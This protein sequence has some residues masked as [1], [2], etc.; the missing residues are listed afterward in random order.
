M[1]GTE[2][3]PI[4]TPT[5]AFAAAS[6]IADYQRWLQRSRGLR[7]DSYEELWRWSVTDLTAFWQSIWDYFE[8]QADAPASAV[9]ADARMPAGRSRRFREASSMSI[10][11]PLYHR[12]DRSC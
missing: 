10:S 7:F 8:L 12:S 2:P 4:W 11:S 5:P 9:L 6:V 3:L 1:S